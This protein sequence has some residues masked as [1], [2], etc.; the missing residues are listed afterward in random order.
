MVNGHLK[1]WLGH[2]LKVKSRRAAS[3]CRGLL[4]ILCNIILHRCHNCSALKFDCCRS[5]VTRCQHTI[6]LVVW[7][8]LSVVLRYSIKA[9][10][11]WSIR[12]IHQSMAHHLHLQHPAHGRSWI[13]SH[14]GPTFL[15][16][17]FQQTIILNPTTS[18][19]FLKNGSFPVN[20][21]VLIRI[22]QQ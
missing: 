7:R 11:L 13:L 1:T 12:W 15:L 6:G 17:L 22:Q 10:S 20:L 16:C 19:Q 2:L 14:R 5:V 4:W 18:L 9:W 8:E 3:V 21:C